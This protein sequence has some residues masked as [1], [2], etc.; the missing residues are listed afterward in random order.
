MD[1]YLW[2]AFK[3]LLGRRNGADRV[4]AIF[5]LTYAADGNGDGNIIDIWNSREDAFASAAN[6]LATEDGNA[7]SLG[8]QVSLPANFNQQLEGIKTEQ[9]KRSH[10]GRR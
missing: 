4:Y 10:N 2:A 5:I 1:I 6:Y 3:R 8:E 7:I 9:Q